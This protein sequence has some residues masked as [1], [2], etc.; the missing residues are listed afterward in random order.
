MPPMLHVTDVGCQ[1]VTIGWDYLSQCHEDIEVEGFVLVRNRKASPD[2]IPYRI[3]GKTI[4]N[5]KPGMKG[6][7]SFS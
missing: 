3:S 2:L 4:K 5:L 7:G 6:W 1:E